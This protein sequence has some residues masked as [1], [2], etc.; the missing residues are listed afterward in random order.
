MR[1]ERKRRKGGNCNFTLPRGE[2]IT[3]ADDR[4]GS[5]VVHNNSFKRCKSAIKSMGKNTLKI[6]NNYFLTYNEALYFSPSLASN[7]AEGVYKAEIRYNLFDDCCTNGGSATVV[8]VGDK[9]EYNHKEITITDNIFSQKERA[10]INAT[11]VN[12]LLFK[13]NTVHTNGESTVENSIIN[14]IRA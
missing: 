9:N 11:G 4:D 5:V 6:T 7:N 8:V 10:V 14:G 13:E 1:Y 3:I 12:Y 2:G